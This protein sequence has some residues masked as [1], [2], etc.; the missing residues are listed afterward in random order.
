[1]QIREQE[2]SLSEEEQDINKSSTNLKKWSANHFSLGSQIQ[3]V[4][5][6]YE[7]FAH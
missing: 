7:Y 5:F 3:N 4:T 1:M 2:Y 6:L